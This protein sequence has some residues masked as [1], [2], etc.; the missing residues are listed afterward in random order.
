[1]S[2]KA[3]PSGPI[4]VDGSYPSGLKTIYSWLTILPVNLPENTVYNRTLGR[5]AMSAL[6][7]VA[8]PF[9]II[10][11]IAALIGIGTTPL[12]GAVLCVIFWAGLNRAMHWDGLADISDAIGSWATPEKAKKILAEPQ[13]GP[14][15]IIT[16]IF[17]ALL[18]V[19]AL[20]K[21][22]T[23]PSWIQLLGIALIPFYARLAGLSLTT[24]G[25]KPLSPSGFGA[26]IIGV[27]KK[28]TLAVWTIIIIVLGLVPA[29][30]LGGSLYPVL[31][32]FVILPIT[33]LGVAKLM[34]HRIYARLG[35]L[36]G[37]AVGSVIEVSTA[38]S[39]LF[40][41]VFL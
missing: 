1:M 38:V 41:A 19:A 24:T 6:P 8:I 14:F 36:N 3:G 18:Q 32:S 34:A 28:S 26:L 7:L 30:F 9:A 37:D 17:V 4:E 27:T 35:G 33:M 10:G 15:A 23:N 12:I 39:A 21:L 31:L 40:L 16:L 29:Y 22:M 11:F 25:H 20:T 13:A 2:G 5:K